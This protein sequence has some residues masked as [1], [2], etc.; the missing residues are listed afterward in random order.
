MTVHVKPHERSKPY[1]AI[2]DAKTEQLRKELQAKRVKNACARIERR[3]MRM[4]RDEFLGL[5]EVEAFTAEAMMTLGNP[6]VGE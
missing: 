4:S 5:L 3:I 1:Q 2:R 6:E